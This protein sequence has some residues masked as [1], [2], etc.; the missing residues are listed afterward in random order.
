M[1]TNC[2]CGKTS[3]SDEH[4]QPLHM[5]AIQFGSWINL[6]RNFHLFQQMNPGN[7]I[8]T[9]SGETCRAT[10]G[11]ASASLSAMADPDSGC[12]CRN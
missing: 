5:R 1:H 2:W 3:A 9:C 7:Y 4:A 6:I 12:K 10:G 11:D 8:K